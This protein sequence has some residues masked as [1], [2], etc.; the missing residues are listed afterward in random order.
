[1]TGSGT[2]TGTTITT[3]GTAAEKGTASGEKAGAPGAAITSRSDGRTGISC[4][5]I[6]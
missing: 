6:P 5:M 3:S 4:L 2:G 1:M